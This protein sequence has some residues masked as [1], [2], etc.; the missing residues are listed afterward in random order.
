[1]N[2]N[3]SNARQLGTDLVEA[4]WI[5]GCCSECAKYRGRWFSISGRDKRFPKM[6]YNYPCSC[7]GIDFSPVILGISEPMYCPCNVNIVAWSNRPFI[8]DRTSAE[9]AAHQHYIDSIIFENVKQKDKLD[10]ERLLKL[11]PEIMPKSFSSY[12]K[13]KLAETE[14]FLT[15]AEK[16]KDYAIDILLKPETKNVITRYNNYEK[17]VKKG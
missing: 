10:Y 3:L 7:Q 8:D 12:R 11:M 14:K 17:L 4:D 6:P 15:I 16:A 13:M 9:R 1:M 2:I 5:D